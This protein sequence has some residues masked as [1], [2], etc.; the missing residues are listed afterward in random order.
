AGGAPSPWL[1]CRCAGPGPRAPP[2]SGALSPPRPHPPVAMPAP[3]VHVV[4]P[5]SVQPAPRAL[6]RAV[7]R[8]DR[9]PLQR[10]RRGPGRRRLAR[11]A[12]VAL[13][14][15]PEQAALTR[16]RAVRPARPLAP[17]RRRS[18]AGTPVTGAAGLRRVRG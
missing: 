9:P 16:E 13:D 18:S 11:G 10:A 1:D 2:L 6:I 14:H 3:P 12:H 17:P 8:R 5:L 7:P 15:R 4:G